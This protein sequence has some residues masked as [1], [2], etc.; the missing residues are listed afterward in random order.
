MSYLL[1]TNAVSEWVKSRSNTGLMEWLAQTDEDELFLSVITLAELRDGTERMSAGARRTRLEAWLDDAL[2]AR[3]G[4][5]VLGIDIGVASDWGR[6]V[7][8]RRKA[9]RPIAAMDALIAA[10]ATRRGLS[11]V[12]RDVADFD[13]LDVPIICPW[14]G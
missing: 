1:D 10:T 7:A 14:S 9:G 5:R 12:T 13:G 4:D 3:F 8:L 2:P 6:I 11:L